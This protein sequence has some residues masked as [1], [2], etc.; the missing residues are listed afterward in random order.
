MPINKEVVYRDGLIYIITIILLI[1]SIMYGSINPDNNNEY[2]IS[3]K[4][5]LFAIILYIGYI[6]LLAKQSKKESLDKIDIDKISLFKT[7][8]FVVIGMAG[9]AVSIYFLVDASLSLFYSLGLSKSVA[10][11]T[12]LALS[13]IHI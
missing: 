9:I 10:G 2:L 6:I 7:M 4:S 5:G 13:L 3:R 1:V 11:L 8:I 12:V